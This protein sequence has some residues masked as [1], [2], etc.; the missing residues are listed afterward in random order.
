MKLKAVFYADGHVAH[1]TPKQYKRHQELKKKQE[2]KFWAKKA[3]R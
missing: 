1:L 3:K 2:Q